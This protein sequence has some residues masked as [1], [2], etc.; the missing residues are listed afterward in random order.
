[1]TTAGSGASGAP[2]L[3]KQRAEYL[4]FLDVQVESYLAFRDALDS[5]ADVFRVIRAQVEREGNVRDLGSFI[6]PKPLR[7]KLSAGLADFERLRRAGQAM[8]FRLLLAE[9][10]TLDDISRA[11]DLPVPVIEAIIADA[12]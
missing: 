10:A 7:A 11:W 12:D 8:L 1:M 9:G 4:A 2:D 3:A 6:D 5:A